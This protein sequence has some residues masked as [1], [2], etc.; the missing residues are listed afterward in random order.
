MNLD[1]FGA[2][3][4]W[5]RRSREA[6]KFTLHC[7]RRCHCITIQRRGSEDLVQAGCGGFEEGIVEPPLGVKEDRVFFPRGGES[8]FVKRF[9][10]C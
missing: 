7:T 5:E 2:L 8:T 10:R 3:A 6:H 4:F 1:F 9:L